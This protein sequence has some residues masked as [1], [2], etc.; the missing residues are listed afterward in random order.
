[1]F[2]D[3]EPFTDRAGATYAG[4]ADDGTFESRANTY[5]HPLARPVVLLSGTDMC[6]K[7]AIDDRSYV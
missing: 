6:P 4:R 2:T 1:M 3:T 7:A 5:D